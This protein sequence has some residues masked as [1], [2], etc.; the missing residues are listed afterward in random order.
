MNRSMVLSV[1]VLVVLGLIVAFNLFRGGGE[2]TPP[3]NKPENE[4]K[5]DSHQVAGGGEQTARQGE[6]SDADPV[7]INRGGTPVK[8]KA[9]VPVKPTVEVLAEW[10]NALKLCQDRIQNGEAGAAL[11]ELGHRYRV[12]TNVQARTYW[13]G[14]LLKWA[15]VYLR[16]PSEKSGL[17][18]ASKIGKGDTLTSVSRR[19]QR[20]KN[21][22]VSPGFLQAI[23]RIGD[24]TK[25][26]IGQKIWLPLGNPSAVVTLSEFRLDYYLGD[27]LFASFLVGTGR[28]DKTPVVDF[29]VGK[30]LE[31]PDWCLNGRMIPYGDP[32]N[33]L[34]ERW[35]GFVHE[36]HQGYGIHG[37]NDESTIGKAVSRGCIRLKN[38]DVIELFR[39][40]PVG[41]AVRIRA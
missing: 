10:E 40:I 38:Q 7:V 22:L 13:R 36:T 5:A 15:I 6:P 20:E 11:R 37:T 32:R 29:K 24:P 21:I 27:C 35:I 1:G 33:E 28:D 23:N 39:L 18:V 25:I 34:G 8:S 16:T 3:E 30:K 12:A 9:V 4:V 17:F 14:P 26:Q 2:N 41:T 31:N 19:H